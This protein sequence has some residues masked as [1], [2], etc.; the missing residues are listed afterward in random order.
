MTGDAELM[1]GVPCMHNFLPVSSPLAHF[2][3]GVEASGAPG[4]DVDKFA[5][6]RIKR[7]KCVRNSVKMEKSAWLR[8]D[9]PMGEGLNGGKM[10]DSTVLSSL[11]VCVQSCWFLFGIVF[12]H[13]SL[14][15]WHP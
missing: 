12:I 9:K 6:L 3:T 7:E 5:W 1:T 13:P 2:F 11:H 15:T 10:Q 14:T 8:I 4:R